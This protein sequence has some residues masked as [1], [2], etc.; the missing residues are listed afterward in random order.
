LK[1]RWLVLAFGIGA[2]VAGTVVSAQP[3]GGFGGRQGGPGGRMPRG[4]MPITGQIVTADIAA[5]TIQ[6]KVAMW[7]RGV[8]EM[9]LYPVAATKLS[10][11]QF[12]GAETLATGDTVDVTGVTLAMRA[13]TIRVPLPVEGTETPDGPGGPPGGMAMMGFR[14]GA[15]RASINGEVI[16]LEPLTVAVDLGEEGAAPLEVT[17]EVP[18]DTSIAREVTAKWG[19]VAPNVYF[20]ATAEMNEQQQFVLTTL[21]LDESVAELMAAAEAAGAAG[22]PGGGPGRGPRGGGV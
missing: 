2:L 10:K 3:G 16:S 14:G 22:G 17:V 1:I 21:T 11:Y 7:G 20:R 4:V 5:G 9:T 15:A 13:S 8:Q 18:G 6:A 12:V 19:E